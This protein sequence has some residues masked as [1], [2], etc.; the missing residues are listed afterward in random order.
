MVKCEIR[1]PSA[2]QTWG[3]HNTEWSKKFCKIIHLPRI[4]EPRYEIPNIESI[5]NNIVWSTSLH[6]LFNTLRKFIPFSWLNMINI[7][8]RRSK[9]LNRRKSLEVVILPQEVSKW[10]FQI[11]QFCH[12]KLTCIKALFAGFAVISGEEKI[13]SFDFTVACY[14]PWRDFSQWII[15]KNNNGLHKDT[16]PF[17]TWTE[18][19]L[20]IS[21]VKT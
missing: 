10:L 5:Y 9:T 12:R 21:C 14:E 18:V 7:N 1:G 19:E 20:G 6:K 15:T 4:K 2:K 11:F 17:K 3:K 16:L 13:Q 8:S